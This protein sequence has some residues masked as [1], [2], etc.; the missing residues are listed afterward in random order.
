M[1]KSG[2]ITGKIVLTMAIL[3]AGTVL[4]TVLMNTFFL[5]NYYARSKRTDLKETFALIDNAALRGTS[6]TESF[7]VAL[8]NV[9]DR[10]NIDAI[11]ISPEG[12]VLRS[13]ANNYD[14]L[15]EQFM[16]LLLLSGDAE[17]SIEET[18]DYVIR[19]QTDTRLQSEYLVLWG[20]LSDGNFVMLRSAVESIRD[21]AALSNRFLLGT[22]LLA[23]VVGILVMLFLTR[24]MTRPIV[25]LSEISKRMAGLDF[26]AKY[27]GSSYREVDELGESMNLLSENLEQTISELK[28]ANNML[29]L[30]NERKTEIDEMRKEF[31][32]NVS[33]EL[34]T[35]LALIRGYAEGLSE[36]IADEDAESR[37]FYCE[38]ITDET[39]KMSRMVGKLLTLNQ[40]EFGGNETHMERFDA[41]EV[42][43]GVLSASS[44]LFEQEGIEVSFEEEES[45]PVW[46]DELLTEEVLT[47]Y[48]SN[49]LHHCESG[50]DGK[51][52][53]RVSAERKGRVLRISVFNTGKPIPE[54]ELPKIWIKFYKVDKARTRQ[55]GGSG[56]GLSIVKASMELMR[57]ECGAVNRE[58]GVEFWMELDTEA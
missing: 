54:E 28:S 21:T 14:E 42:I 50:A 11:I 1:K 15:R 22:G 20:T 58:D 6:G 55:Y 51:K 41:A 47:N 38:V 53:I 52:T 4:F 40:L 19:R 12:T 56:I 45:L 8:E 3:L 16:T 48:V 24:R 44:L 18:D 7:S 32:S 37:K 25:Q 57:Q 2:T 35:P 9:T 43:R 5:D 39:D 27:V 46:A 10:S 33:H 26:D 30:D 31:L 49:A 17:E 13:T 34:K 36:G 29:Q 23:A